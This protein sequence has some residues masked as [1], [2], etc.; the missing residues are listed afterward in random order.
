MNIKSPL[1]AKQAGLVQCHD[2]HKLVPYPSQQV[3][4]CPRCGCAL[5]LRIPN[6]LIHTWAYLIAGAI[7]FVPANLLPIMTVKSIQEGRTDTILSGVIHLAEEGMLPLAL[8]VFVASILVPLMKMFGIVILLISIQFNWRMSARQRTSMY[9]MIEFVG[10]WS[11][12]DIFV[13]TVLVAIVKLGNIATIV[14]GPAA[15]AF[16]AVVVLTMLAAI[17]F[18]PRL[19]WDHQDD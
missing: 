3:M 4:D 1:T 2:C 14:P 8:I 10:R 11:M 15:S 6:S 17:S 19:L 7:L 13:I 12:L 18:D 9:R 16:A 5:H